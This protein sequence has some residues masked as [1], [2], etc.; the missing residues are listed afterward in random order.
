MVE[1]I[2]EKIKAV[3]KKMLS[4]VKS[5]SDLKGKFDIL[6]SMPGIGELSALNILADLPE[7]GGL[8]KGAIASL[9]GVA[10][11]TQQSGKKQ[12]QSH[13]R[14]G[15]G[16]L[17]K[18]L[19]MAA[20]VACRC[21]PLM[22]TFYERLCAKGKPKKV[23]IIAVLRKMLITLNAM[24]KGKAQWKNWEAERAINVAL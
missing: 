15:R 18:V 14:Y 22:K 21:N 12:G 24:I 13:I 10:P 23:G 7:I 4:L 5:D 3:Q 6:Q 11:I 17:R 19:Y 8:S 20:L 1:V 2:E 9:V 16:D